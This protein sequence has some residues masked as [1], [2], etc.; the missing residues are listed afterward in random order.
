MSV[1]PSVCQ[2]M[3]FAAGHGTRMRPLTNSLPK[4]MVELNGEPLLM[5]I[6]RHLDNAGVT[7]IVINGHHAVDKLVDYMPTVQSKFPHIDFVLSI[8]DA[9][10]DT[11]GGTVQALQYL[12]ITQPLY[13]INGDAYWVNSTQSNTLADLAEAWNDADMDCLL[14]LQKSKIM[15]DY[16]MHDGMAVRAHDKSGRYAF[17][18]VRVMHPRCIQRRTLNKFS[19]LE[20]MDE[21][22]RNERLSAINHNGTWYHL[23]TP[24]DV[25]ETEKALSA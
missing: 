5:H 6:I 20:V 15:G 3:I 11:G 7:K 8:E 17:T 25:L 14:L 9:L 18:G 10:L 1:K 4:P 24:S 13:M 2:A 19:F 23:S 21:C 16:N 22:E 12:D